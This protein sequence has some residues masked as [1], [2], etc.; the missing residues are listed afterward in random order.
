VTGPRRQLGEAVG[1]NTKD[2]ASRATRRLG[3]RQAQRLAD[4]EDVFR[5]WLHLPDVGALHVALGTIASNLI[6]G[7]PVWLLEVGAPS[8]GKTEV[9]GAF[10][11]LDYVHQAAT[12]TEAGLLSGSPKRE[13]ASDATGGLLRKVGDFGILVAKDFGSVLSMHQAEQAKVL[14]ALR[15][16]YDGSWNRD[17]GADGGRSLRWRGKC[18]FLGG[19]TPTIDRAHGVM[20]ALGERFLLY[21]VNVDDAVAQGRRRVANRGHERQAGVRPRRS[22]FVFRADRRERPGDDTGSTS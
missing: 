11:R 7:D 4:T 15:E 1:S 14:A 8:S 3:H 19:C 13:Q 18:G 21:R 2:Q 12:L 9:V 17:L 6:D 10:A 16:V 22:S 20:G 5:R